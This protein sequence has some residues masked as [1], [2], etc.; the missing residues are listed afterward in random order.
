MAN[1]T[2]LGMNIILIMTHLN[3]QSLAFS[4]KSV[5]HELAPFICVISR[6]LSYILYYALLQESTQ[7]CI[8]GPRLN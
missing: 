6:L 5:L 1:Q 3:E 7:L 4:S 2:I 8:L